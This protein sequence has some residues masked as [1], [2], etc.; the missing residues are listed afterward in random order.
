MNDHK[1]AVKSFLSRYGMDYESMDMDKS[2][3]TFIEEMEKGLEGQESS[4]K[5]LP[6]YITVDGDIPLGEPVIVMDAGGTNFRVA[7]I[8]FD[9]DKKPVVQ[10]YRL[11]PMPGT[12]GEI[13][14]E[15][16]F[17]TMAG[18]IEPVLDRSKK[19]GF[20]FSYAT[21]ILPNKDGKLLQFSKEIKVKDLI[22]EII[23]ENLLRAVKNS[24]FDGDKKIVL[25]N[26][27]VAT[28]L[29]GKAAYP[30][31]VFDG[32]IGFILGTG[33]NTCYIEENRN[34]KK[35]CDLVGKAGSTVI[36]MESGG[37]DK[38]PRGLIDKEFDETTL[39]PGV[40]TFE[41]MISGRYQGGLMLQIIK[42]AAEDGL[43]S[44]RFCER[45]RDIEELS[46]REINDFLY[47]PY[48]DNK[49]SNCCFEDD[50]YL[51]VYHLIDSMME[52]AAKLVA[53]NLSSIILKTGKGKNPCKPVCI[54]AEGTTFYKS[55]LFKNKLDFYMKSYL[56]DEK[57]VYYEFVRAENA[58]LVGAAI[59][60]LIN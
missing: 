45:V 24:G 50:D 29:G 9:R 54:A 58:T 19:I 13:S 30:D 10:D 12:Q 42:R 56:N 55:K 14:K 51:I 5:M 31:R 60:G 35:A 20:C 3:R 44:G 49:L 59:A 4:L 28:L 57:H 21:E 11:Y 46:A 26:D 6:T 22:G 52:R 1:A 7:V 53:V 8:H 37:Y 38:A 32:Y 17:E 47:Y 36:N 39:N 15:E 27:T 48:S 43:F 40:Y 2:C 34:I 23:G 16:F 33:T 41:K 25:L 18:Y